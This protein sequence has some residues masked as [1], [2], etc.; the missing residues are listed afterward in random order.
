MKNITFATLFALLCGCSSPFSQFY[1]DRT[2]GIDISKSPNIILTKEDPKLNRGG[3]PELDTQRM[4]EDGF[5]L[6][7]F[8]HFNAGNVNEHEAIWQAKKVKASVILIY[9]NYTTTVSGTLPLTLPDTR[10]TTTSSYGN[11]YGSGGYANYSGTSYSTTYGTRT[12]YMPYSVNRYD[13]LATYWVKLKDPVFGAHVTDIGDEARKKFG[14]NKGVM[15]QAVVKHSPAYMA[16]ILKGDIIRAIGEVD[17]YGQSTFQEAIEK[18]R[19]KEVNIIIL[20]DEQE[21]SKSVKMK[22]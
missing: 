11:V 13:Y 17:M 6:I 20:R 3:N 2:G 15:V 7:G 14:S 8:S 1:Y 21:L 9:S 16:D 18:Y 19:G 10:T 12:T 22:Y 5:G 4:L